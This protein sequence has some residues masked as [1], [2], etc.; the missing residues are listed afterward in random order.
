MEEIKPPT[1]M[2][3]TTL[4]A[5]FRKESNKDGLFSSSEDDDDAACKVCKD[6]VLA[7]VAPLCDSATAAAVAAL[8]ETAGRYWVKP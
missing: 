5:C 2:P 4:V 8:V 7:N 1:A 3:E 6:A